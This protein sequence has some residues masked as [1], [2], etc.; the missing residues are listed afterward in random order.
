MVGTENTTLRRLPPANPYPPALH[1]NPTPPL[2]H[3]ESPASSPSLS[4]RERASDR[5]QPLYR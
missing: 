5:S 3:P 4:Q 1:P 2:A